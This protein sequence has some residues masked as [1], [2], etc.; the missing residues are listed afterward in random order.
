MS[1]LMV[2]VSGVRGIVGAELNPLTVASWTNALCRLLTPG[3]VVLGRDSRPSGEALAEAAS[4][5]LRSTGREVW[6]IG[7]VPTP[8]VQLAVERWRACGGIILS[9]SHN[10]SRWNALKLVDGDG[11]FLSPDRF[12]ALR[13]LHNTAPE[14]F[15]EAG[16]Y[17]ARRDRHE[18]ALAL[19]IG[20]VLA[21]VDTE[22]IRRARLRVLLDTGHGAGGTLLPMLA[23]ELR[24]DLQGLRLDPDGQLP[25]NPEPT[26]DTLKPLL[27]VA[28]D[29]RFVAMVDP[30]ADRFALGLPGTPY[31][32]EEWTLPL[33]ARSLLA[34]R[35]GPIVTNLST[36][37]LVEAAAA[38]YGAE[39]V[40]TPVGEAYVVAAMKLRGAILGGE[41]NGGI[42]DPSIHLGRDSAAAFARVCEAE[43]SVP[44]GLRALASEFPARA[45]V[46]EK[47]PAPEQGWE[48][49][50]GALIAILGLPDDRRDGLWWRRAEGFVHVRASNTEPIVRAVAEAGDEPSARETIRR[51]REILSS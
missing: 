39:V 30:D 10:P 49:A 38:R 5:M 3:P 31:F 47:L 14:G 29:A 41:G 9:A 21:A 23:R 43:V 19:H 33:L 40:R 16:G 46:K 1:P 27:K 6:D 13:D 24:V 2:S 35:R 20:S 42:I 11:S 4:A 12:A 15:S 34:R 18:E 26:A 37:T 45:M 7:I 36:S 50:Q 51:I 22:R 17:A 32:G 48:A 28:P 44:G 8:T 25:D